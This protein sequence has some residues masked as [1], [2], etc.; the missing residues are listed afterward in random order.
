MRA[1]IRASATDRA[2]AA[3]RPRRAPKRRPVRRRVGSGSPVRANGAR[4]AGASTTVGRRPRTDP[5]TMPT[6]APGADRGPSVHAGLLLDQLPPP[7]LAGYEQGEVAFA[8]DTWPL[9]AA[10]ELRSAL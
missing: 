9:K 1:P 10:E 3:R 2:R 4:A 8:R 5:P 6:V 7:A